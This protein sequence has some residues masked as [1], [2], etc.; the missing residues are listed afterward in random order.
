[1]LS[2]GCLEF[3][4]RVGWRGEPGHASVRVCERHGQPYARGASS[5]D[6]FRRVHDRI[7]ERTART[8]G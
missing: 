6:R 2:V 7:G 4:G 3:E 8:D 5:A 1:M